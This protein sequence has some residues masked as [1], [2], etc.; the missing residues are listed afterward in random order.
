MI[1]IYTNIHIYMI[2]CVPSVN[3]AAHAMMSGICARAHVKL[4]LQN[5]LQVG[6]WE[7]Q[8]VFCNWVK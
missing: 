6:A 1:Y 3:V 5:W 4:R 7:G 8:R 2:Q